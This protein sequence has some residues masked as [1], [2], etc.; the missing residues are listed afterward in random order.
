M[1]RTSFF[2]AFLLI[3]AELTVASP[4]S[5][6]RFDADSW[7][8][9]QIN[10]LVQAARLAYDDDSKTGVYQKR[11]NAISRT[12][13]QRRLKQ[14]EGL[15]ARYREFFNYVDN[16]SL[17]R[18]SGHALGFATPDRKY[19]SEIKDRVEIPEFLTERRFLRNV[20]RYETLERAKAYLRAENERR[21]PSDQLLFFSFRSQHLGTPDNDDSFRRLLI[22][23]PGDVE[24]QIPEK[25]VQF[26]VTDPGARTRIRNLS[27]VAA[28]VNRDGTFDAYFRD[29]FRTYRKDGRITIN[30]RLESGWGDDNCASCHKSGVLPIF[31]EAGSVP[32]NELE[33]VDKVNSRFVGYGSPGFAGYLDQN[34]FGPGLGSTS[35]QERES[36]FGAGFSESSIG[37]AMRCAECHSPNGLA[38][39]NWPM[40]N[41]IIGSFIRGGHMPPGANLSNSER[42]ELYDRLIEE[43][44]S[45]DDLHPGI[46]KSWLLGLRR[47]NP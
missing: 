31:P 44:F 15:V 37:R 40:D 47:S 3:A 18:T 25:W 35:T 5:D 36:R 24:K 21:S 6:S 11:L 14:N 39:L 43:Y 20:S 23:V 29:Y 34:V 1:L 8:R 30:G 46:L 10:R 27:V 2:L 13:R 7:V 42:D 9:T 22:V 41:V 16:I 17:E 12:I 26:G 4:N 28:Q 45:V 32:K 33:T 19:F 38:P